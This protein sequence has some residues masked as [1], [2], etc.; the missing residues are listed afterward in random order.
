MPDTQF[1]FP[2]IIS[3]WPGFRRP[4]HIRCLMGAEPFAYELPNYDM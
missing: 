3:A 2:Q 1:P 4:N